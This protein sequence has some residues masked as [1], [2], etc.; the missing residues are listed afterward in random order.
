M[1]KYILGTIFTLF[2]VSI[3]TFNGCIL[4][5]FKT[6][7]QNVAL[8]QEF[9]INSSAT[10]YSKLATVNLDSSSV[11]QRYKDKI[12]EIKFIRAEY[13]TTSINQSN[14]SGTIS[15]TI[16]NMSDQVLFQVN[17][18]QIKLADYQNSPLELNLTQVQIAL[19]NSY[20]AS[21]SSSNRQ[22]KVSLDITN[23][24]PTPYQFTG[25]VDMVFELNAN[26]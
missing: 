20:L 4:D 2:A 26:T 7:T 17:L 3:V 1:K 10:S 21:L 9:S 14:L 23:I 13:R 12:N 18:G 24:S 16:K 22:F 19:F 5:A 11:Y 6:I 8:T 15:V 25:V